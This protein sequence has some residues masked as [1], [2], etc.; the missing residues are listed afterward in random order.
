MDDITL[1]KLEE[2]S[3]IKQFIEF[4]TIFYP[5]LAPS[6]YKI[7]DIEKALY[8]TYIQLIGKILHISPKSM[9]IF[10]MNYMLKYEIMNIKNIILGTILGIRVDEKNS[11]INF[12]V[13]KFLD[14]ENFIKDL[15]EITSLEEIQLFMRSTIYNRVIREGILYFKNTNEIFVLEAFLDQLYYNNLKNQVKNLTQKEKTMISSYINY[16]SEIYNLNIIY[17]GIKNNIDKNL[18]MQFLVSNYLFTDKKKLT[19][20]AN[21]K[22]VKEFTTVLSKFLTKRKELRSS[23]SRNTLDDEHFIWSVEKLYLD[24]YFKLIETKKVDIEYQAIIKILEILIKKD[25]EIRLFILPKLVKIVHEKYK[26]L[27]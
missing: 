17:R 21:L 14:N 7:E 11:M 1:Q 23:L 22:N 6:S 19:E 15:I 8:H 20:F 2:I 10:L 24:Y 9:R 18:L 5:G 27:K 13:E 3:D 4:I 26:L 25:K 16:V 12:L